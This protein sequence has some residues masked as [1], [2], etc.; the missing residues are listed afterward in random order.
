MN[1]ITIYVFAELLWTSLW[2]IQRNGT[3]GVTVTLHE[4][5]C[6]H[7]LAPLTSPMNASP[8]FALAVA[9]APYIIAR[10]LSSRKL[11]VKI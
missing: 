1:A 8:L 3:D 10:I 4:F 7:H 5:V 6:N 9:L 11:F 2:L